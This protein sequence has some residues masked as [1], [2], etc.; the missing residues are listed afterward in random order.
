[1]FA[2]ALRFVLTRITFYGYQKHQQS[3][4]KPLATPLR[5]FVNCRIYNLVL[6]KN[7]LV[8]DH[9]KALAIESGTKYLQHGKYCMQLIIGFLRRIGTRHRT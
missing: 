6:I 4:E 3:T 9:V 1:M 2:G 5:I 7:V 8:L